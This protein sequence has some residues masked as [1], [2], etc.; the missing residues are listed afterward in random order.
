M[1]GLSCSAAS[2]GFWPMEFEAQQH[3]FYYDGLDTGEDFYKSLAP[4]E[5]IWKKF[6]LLPT[7]PMSPSRTWAEF[8]GW[9]APKPTFEEDY[10]SPYELE[11]EPLDVLANLSSIVL[12]DCMWSG[13]AAG[14]Q[15]E[16][17]SRD[18]KVAP[19][20]RAQRVAPAMTHSSPATQCVSPAA[21][22]SLPGHHGKKT[23]SGSSGSDSHSDSS[24]EDEID[25]VTVDNRP[26][27]GRPPVRRTPVTIAVS[28]DPHG[29][30]PKHFHISLH[31][32]QHNYAAPS[33]ESDRDEEEEE[34][35]IEPQGKRARLEASSSSSSPLSSPA[36]SDSED[37]TEQR[38]NFLERKRRDDLRSRFQALRGEIPGL[39]ESAKTSKVAILT[40]AT[41]YLMQ[42]RACERRQNQERKKLRA[43][44]QQLLRKITA[45][46]NS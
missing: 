7:P 16:K 34:D 26:K 20:A 8:P 6:E 1:P 40:R 28:A 36:S 31:R 18:V 21:V 44:Q 46:K 12:K 10:G 15:L 33:P 14:Q 39:S 13:L 22:L 30:C 25:V 5:D 24:D 2:D 4:S 43:K 3:Y 17:V 32:Q 23:A 35:D 42:L 27:R 45:L 9:M 41:D 19:T 38:R 29:P 11:R 37:A